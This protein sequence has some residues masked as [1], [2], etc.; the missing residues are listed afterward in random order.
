MAKYTLDEI[1]QMPP[2]D[3]ARL[4]QDELH[5]VLKHAQSA[6]NRRLRSLEKAGVHSIAATKLKDNGR[7]TTRGTY[8]QQQ[9]ELRRALNFLNSTTSTVKGVRQVENN[10]I[11]RVGVEMD[12]NQKSDFWRVYNKVCETNPNLLF[13]MGSAELQRYIARMMNN[14]K[15]VDEI[16]SD[17]ER[18]IT[19]DY[20]RQQLNEFQDSPDFGGLTINDFE[21]F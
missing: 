14:N 9:S 15:S 20:E 6:V 4:K 13:S 7:I 10:F 17:A 2:E 1:Q 19:E 3:R 12:E 18:R 16:L 21:D 8:N 11:E 5:D